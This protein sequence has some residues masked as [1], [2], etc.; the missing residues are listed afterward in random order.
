MGYHG[1]LLPLQHGFRL[2]I[3][4]KAFLTLLIK[5]LRGTESLLALVHGSDLFRVVAMSW[6][7]TE[8]AGP[9]CFIQT[10]P[11]LGSLPHCLLPLFF[12]VRSPSHD[13]YGLLFYLLMTPAE[14]PQASD[15]TH[16]SPSTFCSSHPPPLTAP[17]CQGIL[18]H[19]QGNSSKGTSQAT[20]H[21]IWLLYLGCP[22][23]ARA[24][25]KCPLVCS[26]KSF[27]SFHCQ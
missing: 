7:P 2:S 14:F 13:P 10:P 8:L 12:P 18:F 15:S 9:Q 26:S 6:Q 4:W 17:A 3:S 19:S 20:T 11:L 1:S 25:G 27:V 24:L 21:H 16:P 23:P 22:L 5:L